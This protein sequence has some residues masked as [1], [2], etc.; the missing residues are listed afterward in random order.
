MASDRS[1]SN[2]AKRIPKR[3]RTR[4]N[5]DAANQKILQGP[6]KSRRRLLQ[7][8]E[9]LAEVSLVS[10]LAGLANHL[11]CQYA[12][13]FCEEPS[14]LRCIA[15][16]LIVFKNCNRKFLMRFQQPQQSNYD[17]PSATC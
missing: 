3:V 5:V 15:T 7:Q 10:A 9:L 16:T 13:T 6:T 14:S 2:K 8:T 12:V 4:E 1:V 17:M 11:I